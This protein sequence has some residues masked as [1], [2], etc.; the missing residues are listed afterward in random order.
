MNELDDQ[1]RDVL[2]R[3]EPPDGF[4]ERVRRRVGEHASQNPPTTRVVRWL[5][6]AAV[7]VAV[8]GAGIQYRTAQMERAR[9]ER[10]EGEAAGQSVMLAL[11]IAG[12]KLQLVQTRINR[13]HEQ[14]DKNAIQ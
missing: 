2:R 3:E 6:A 1:L 14:P 7:V 5:A 9:A 12:S 4:V 10:A 11:H 8:A 13:L